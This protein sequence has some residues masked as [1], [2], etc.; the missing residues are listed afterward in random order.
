[1]ED[2]RSD[3]DGEAPQ[4]GA[5][6]ASQSPLHPP[7]NDPGPAAPRTDSGGHGQGYAPGNGP[8]PASPPQQP[9]TPDGQPLPPWRRP[10]AP[11]QPTPW[12]PPEW[13]RPAFP[14]PQPQQGPQYPPGGQWRPQY[15]PPRQQPPYGPAGTWQAPPPTPG[16]AID[17]FGAAAG[18]RPGRVPWTWR[19]VLLALVIAAAPIVALSVLGMLVSTDTTS[20]RPAPTTGFALVS[21]ILTLVVDGWFVLWAWFF[22]LRKYRLSWR[23]FGYR[24]YEQAKYWGVAA[25]FILGGLVVTYV[26]SGLNDF[27]Y[28]KVFGP[29]PQQDVVSLFPHAAPGLVLFIVL[30]VIIA[31][32]LE[33]TV[34]RGFVFQGLA[35]S[36]G[37]V[38]GALVSALVFAL[39]H[40]Q[41]SVLFP[42]FVLGLLLAGAFYWTK[43]I[44]TNIAFHAIFNAV[45]VVA[46][47][48]LR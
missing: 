7:E 45:G 30:A 4:A 43:S 36:W 8:W 19:D 32:V 12:P 23:S 13:Q 35:N 47:W 46:W 40:Q 2:D 37:P 48:F 31:P 3:R 18:P 25:A 39:I 16:P 10:S 15:G 44:Y 24:G 9:I 1:V 42:I 29:V 38:A 21:V 11:Q 20:L 17:T 22:S 28:R 41:L 33:E 6:D 26:L 34:F 5:P 14:P 27:V